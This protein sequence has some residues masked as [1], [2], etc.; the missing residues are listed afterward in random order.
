MKKGLNSF[1]LKCICIGMMIVG[2]YM[3][4]LV[5]IL[6]EETV[7]A[8]EQLPA[9]ITLTYNMGYLLYLAAFPL[10]SFLLVVAAKKTADR[11]RLMRRLFITALLVEIPMDMATFGLSEWK[12][13][14]LNQNYFFT[15]CI[16]LGVIMAVDAL[17]KKYAVGTMGNTLSTLGV[18]LLGAFLAILARTEQNSIGVLVVITLY[19][20]YGNK[21]FSLVSVAALYLFFMQRSTGLEYIPAL[22]V[23][24]TWL[25][26]G[27]QGKNGKVSR[28]VFY[29]AFPVAYCA[30]GILAK[31]L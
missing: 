30:L 20:F 31:M 6:N 8:G 1:Q 28:G 11:K 27:E 14:G 21:M 22:G 4:Q 7:L 23:L 3:Q 17:G 15:L 25:Y 24:L 19:L 26:N 18:Y 2:V 5:Y 16:A 12:D 29:F 10:A 13:W 9:G